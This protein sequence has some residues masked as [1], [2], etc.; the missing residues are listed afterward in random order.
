L[1]ASA[2]V[3]GF[4]AI[5]EG[6][7]TPALTEVARWCRDVV[8]VDDTAEAALENVGIAATVGTLEIG[9]N[10]GHTVVAE[11]FVDTWAR[12]AVAGIVVVVVVDVVAAPV[13]FAD[14]SL[15]DPDPDLLG[16]D[17]ET[18]TSGG[19]SPRGPESDYLAALRRVLRV[20]R[21][22]DNYSGLVF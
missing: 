2:V 17:R 12:M 8:V 5:V 1:K 3:A 20:Y 13:V 15:P 16:R 14:A 7:Y 9:H 6:H 19:E 21:R 22:C 11:E 4:V 10:V 18:R